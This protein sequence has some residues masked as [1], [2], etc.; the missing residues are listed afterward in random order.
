VRRVLQLPAFRSLLAAY[1]LNELAYSFGSLALALL[2]LNRTSSVI[3]TAGYFLV[4]QFVPALVAPALVSRI[5]RVPVRRALPALYGLETA[6]FLVLAWL[7]SHFSLAAVL[8]VAL[9]DGVLALVAR[10][11]ARAAG[12]A[13]TAPVG[14]LREG[15]AITNAAFSLCFMAGPAVAGGVVAAGGTSIALLVAAGLFAAIVLT[16]LTATTLPVSAPEVSQPRRLQAAIRYAW[17]SRPVRALLGLQ[18]LAVLFFSISIPVEVVFATRTL[19]AG[20][21]GFGLL[22]AGWGVGAVG[23]SAAYARFRTRPSRALI[24]AGAAALAVGLA[25]MAVA[26]GL[27]VALVGAVVAGSGNGVEAVAFRTSLQEHTPQ[28]WMALIMSLGD[29]LQQAVP[30][31]GILLGGGVAA[32]ADPRAALALAAAGAAVVVAAA[33]PLLGSRVPEEALA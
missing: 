2:V 15:N 29:S 4:S 16:L 30:G 11:L 23:G 14:L 5:D 13:V 22:T 12:V 1:T 6:A 31:G 9:A 26:P 17:E 24:C 8:L 28:R 10:A 21:A 25:V 7:T 33:W 32:V 27:A 18:A 3:A 20:A 19:H